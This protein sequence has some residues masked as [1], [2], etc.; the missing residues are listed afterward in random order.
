MTEKEELSAAEL[1]LVLQKLTDSSVALLAAYGEGLAAGLD[2][3]RRTQS[4][5][6]AKS[7]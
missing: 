3:A 1:E 7:P 6:Q 4:S 2:L 5:E